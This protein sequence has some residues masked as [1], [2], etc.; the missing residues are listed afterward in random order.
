MLLFSAMKTEQLDYHLPYELIAQEPAKVRSDARM[1]VVDRKAGK[2]TDDVFRNVGAYIDAGDA[3]VMNDTRVIRAR[4]KAQKLTGGKIE[5][6]LLR[7]LG[8]GEWE[9]LVRPSSRTKPGSKVMIGGSVQ[10][11]ILEPINNGRRRVRFDDSDVLASLQKCGEIPLPPYIQRDANEEIDAERYQ[12]VYARAYGAVAAPTAGLHFTKEL[13]AELAEKGVNRATLTLHV[14]YGT[15]KP[16]SVADLDQHKVD[17]EEFVFTKETAELLN[18]TRSDKHRVIAVGTTSTR[19]LET[20]FADGRFQTGAGLTDCYIYPPYE[21]HGVDALVSN[22]HL[23]KSSLLALVCAFGGRDLM[24]SAY[25]HAV[26]EEYRFY[27]Y[28]DAMIIL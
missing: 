13:L 24:M 27:S 23:P 8:L 2:F 7:E 14:G 17:E 12:T 26:K 22:F 25:E 20:Q 16:I 6:F 1:L 5:V 15:F 28:G 11:T 4:L 10:A 19:V 9:A 18:K 3:L 21:F